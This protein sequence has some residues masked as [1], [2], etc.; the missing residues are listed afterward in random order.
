MTLSRDIFFDLYKNV[1]K[2]NYHVFH[3]PSTFFF[4]VTHQKESLEEIVTTGFC[5]L[6]HICCV[7]YVRP[8]PSGIGFRCGQRITGSLPLLF[9]IFSLYGVLTHMVFRHSHSSLL[10]RRSIS[11]VAYGEGSYES[12][13]KS[14]RPNV[15]RWGEFF[16]IVLSLVVIWLGFY[17]KI[18]LLCVISSLIE[19]VQKSVHQEI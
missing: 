9:Y 4:S 15:P 8:M 13:N 3:S 12:V 18:D 2:L 1:P 11:K 17:T 14:S 5:R 7:M 16:F 6:V 19:G 10:F